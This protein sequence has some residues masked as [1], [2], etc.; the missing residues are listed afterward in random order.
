MTDFM[1]EWKTMPDEELR[2]IYL[3]RLRLQKFLAWIPVA[4]IVPAM[5]I[6]GFLGWLTT[7]VALGFHFIDTSVLGFLDFVAFAVCGV[8]YTTRNPKTIKF[9]PLVMFMHIILKL[10]ITRTFTIISIIFL[11]YTAFASFILRQI[12]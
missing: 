2:K 6:Y 4:L 8:I 10:L 3:N 5:I 1:T 9:I 12:V 11:I 7:V